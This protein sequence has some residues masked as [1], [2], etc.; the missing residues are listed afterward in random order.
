MVGRRLPC[1]FLGKLAEIANF[2]KENEIKKEDMK[3]VLR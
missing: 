2:S 3:D 1:P